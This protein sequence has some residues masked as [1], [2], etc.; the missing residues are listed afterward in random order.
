MLYEVITNFEGRE[1]LCVQPEALT[2]LSEQAFRD[3]SHLLRPAHL[4][5]LS[6]ILDDPESTENDKFVARELLKNAVIVITSYSIHYTKLYDKY[7]PAWNE[8]RGRSDQK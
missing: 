1:I 3:V 7:C 2:L 5:Q 8:R 6:A 4:T